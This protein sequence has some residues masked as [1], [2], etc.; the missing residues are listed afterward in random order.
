MFNVN[1]RC[2]WLVARGII[3]QKDLQWSHDNLWQ[4]ISICH[5]QLA[6]ATLASF[7]TTITTAVM[8]CPTLLNTNTWNQWASIISIIVADTLTNR[9]IFSVTKATL[10]NHLSVRKL[11]PLH[12]SYPSSFILRLLSLLLMNQFHEFQELKLVYSSDLIIFKQ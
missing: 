4:F 6:P 2:H 11:N 3:T 10:F 12:P 9:L 1:P 7:I 5:W 8:I